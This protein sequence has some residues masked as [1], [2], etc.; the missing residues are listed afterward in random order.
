MSS[1]LNHAL[2]FEHDWQMQA[3]ATPTQPDQATPG[4]AENDDT[5]KSRFILNRLFQHYPL[6]FAV[7][8]W[9]GSML[10]IGKDTPAFTLCLE[11]ASVL[12]DMVLFNDPAR[13]AEAYFS[14]EVQILGDF[15]AAMQLRYYFESLSLPLTEKLGLVY[16]AL[17]LAESQR[18]PDTAQLATI[19]QNQPAY[20]NSLDYAAPNDFYSLWL[21]DKMLHSCA[22]FCDAKQ[23]L[24]QAQHN[25][26]DLIC[27]KLHLQH[28]DTL[29]DIGGGWGGLACW[30]ARHYGVFVH[31][32]TQHPQ[33]HAHAVAEV[34]KQGLE[35]LVTVTLCHY[36][37]LPD[38]PRYDKVVS[39]GLASQTG[40]HNLPA[41]LAKVHA[42]LKPGGLFLDHEVTTESPGRQH[43]LATRFINR[44]VFPDGELS[45]LPHIR[46]QMQS[47]SL[48]VFDVEALR[49]HH[50]LTLRRW[51]SK[52]EQR[53]QEVAASF[54]ERTY[55]IWR[56]YMTASAIQFEQG[57][58]GIHQILA[59]RR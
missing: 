59:V 25:Q 1:N 42:V 43:E 26:L 36:R 5:S 13:L 7:R 35:K 50:A 30:A 8:L 47:A 44:Q 31:C 6:S 22:Y 21:D 40:E 54:G 46:Q 53:H 10:Y 4:L 16:R 28:G 39:I 51:V 14:G 18:A 27:L 57:V 17:T 56:L 2:Q 48:E 23:D 37:D 45:S 33:Q 20:A 11:Q 49:R 55:R 34:Q 52:L 12:R 24:A 32:I 29:L 38:T 19:H 9:N 15:D 58:T 3:F 41:Y